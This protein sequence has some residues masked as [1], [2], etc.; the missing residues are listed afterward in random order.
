MNRF[1][2]FAI[3]GLKLRPLTQATAQAQAIKLSA[4]NEGFKL[5]FTAVGS[6]WSAC[7]GHGLGHWVRVSG[8]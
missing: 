7:P 8:S 4:Q 6:A 3:N 1:Q 2:T 5:L